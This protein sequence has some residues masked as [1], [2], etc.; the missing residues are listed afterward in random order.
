M[1]GTEPGPGLFLTN[2]V[3]LPCI[4]PAPSGW[5]WGGTTQPFPANCSSSACC[6]SVH[7][8][9]ARA[10]VPRPGIALLVSL[11]RSSPFL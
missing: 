2:I 1:G 10:D 3:Y 4:G 9:G 6:R 7:G 5:H 8:D 11:G